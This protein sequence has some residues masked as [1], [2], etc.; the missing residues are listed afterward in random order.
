MQ[1][2]S[3]WRLSVLRCELMF[4]WR[5]HHGRN[6]DKRRSRSRSGERRSRSR[7]KKRRARS[8]S[9]SR[10][11]HRHHS[12][13]RSK[14]RWTKILC[15]GSFLWVNLNENAD[16]CLNREMVRFYLGRRRRGQR[17]RGEK[18]A[19]GQ[20]ALWPSGVETQPWMLRKHWLEGRVT[21]VAWKHKI[22][23]L[24]FIHSI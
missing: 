7:E 23:Y 22:N 17:K 19:V 21:S 4:S 13:S 24:D 6:W 2:V 8:R 11:K 14:S 1:R 18:V 15:L 9:N 3:L 20:L 12:R 5:R 10:S 16:L